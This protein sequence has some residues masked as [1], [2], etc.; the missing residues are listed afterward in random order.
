MLVHKEDLCR[1]SREFRALFRNHCTIEC[2]RDELGEFGDMNEMPSPPKPTDE[3]K[4][5]E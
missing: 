5:H 4:L 3:S 1:S 2:E